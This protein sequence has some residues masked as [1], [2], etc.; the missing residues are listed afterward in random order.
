MSDRQHRSMAHLHVVPSVSHGLGSHVQLLRAALA[1]IG[2][3][4]CAAVAAGLPDTSNGLQCQEDFSERALP[5]GS[6][7]HG[8]LPAKWVCQR[9]MRGGMGILFWQQIVYRIPRTN[10]Y[11]GK[12]G[13]GCVLARIA[14]LCR[15][16]PNVH[17]QGVYLICT[18]AHISDMK[19]DPFSLG[20]HSGS[21]M[22]A[23]PPPY[24]AKTT[25][26]QCQTAETQ[27]AASMPRRLCL[28]QALLGSFYSK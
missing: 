19:V 14:C 2:H 24:I 11:R 18:S 4:R 12:K 26:R 16:T 13:F 3:M 6:K 23:S 27:S 1:T 10:L 28:L 9:C 17:H 7:T 15:A 21:G 20:E 5:D 22:R 25:G 8:Q